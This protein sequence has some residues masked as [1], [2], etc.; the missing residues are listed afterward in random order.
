MA[1]ISKAIATPTDLA[2]IKDV[3]TFKIADILTVG[4]VGRNGSIKVLDST[5]ALRISI[6]ASGNKL[7]FTAANGNLLAELG[8]NGNLTIGGTGNDGDLLMND[9]AGKQTISLSGGNGNGTFG[10]NGQDG[11][12]YLKN[13]AGETTVYLDGGN[14]NITLGGGGSDGDLTITNSAGATTISMNGDSGDIVLNN[15][16]FAED[17]AISE[18]VETLPGMVMVI[19]AT[20]ELEPCTMGYDKR[21]V[22]VISGAGMYKPGIIMDKQSGQENRSPVSLMGKVMCLVDADHGPVEA[23]DLLTSSP[24]S[25]HAM[26]ADV[27]KQY[28]GTIIG[29]ALNSLPKGRGMV[30]MLISLQ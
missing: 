9:G 3:T 4:S 20:G 8:T 16:D 22:G 29:K 19:N 24:T 11:D 6:E 25:G 5:G 21:A 12:V 18:E 7:K 2:L 23:G 17:F 13:A 26:K 27:Q 30:K 15:A 1:K 14:G 28:A 10:G